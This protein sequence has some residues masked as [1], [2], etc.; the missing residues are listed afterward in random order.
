MSIDK[1]YFFNP[2]GNVESKKQKRNN[3]IKKMY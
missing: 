1:L 2:I 3:M